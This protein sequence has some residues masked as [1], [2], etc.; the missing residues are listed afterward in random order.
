[1]LDR[2]LEARIADGV[3]SAPTL[4]YGRVREADPTHGRCNTTALAIYLKYRE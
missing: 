3:H 2:E 4:T 1:V